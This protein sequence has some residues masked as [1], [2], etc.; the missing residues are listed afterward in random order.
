LGSRNL[1]TKI[2]SAST[3]VIVFAKIS[4]IE[5]T[6]NPCQSQSAIPHVN[7]TYIASEIDFV[8]RDRIVLIVWGKKAAVVKN[9]AI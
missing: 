9:A 4:G 5:S 6:N 7:I 1:S 3:K 2:I 8:S